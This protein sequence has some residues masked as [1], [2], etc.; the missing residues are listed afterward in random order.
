MPERI[1]PRIHQITLRPSSRDKHGVVAALGFFDGVHIGHLALFDEARK[2]AAKRGAVFAVFTFTDCGDGTYKAGAPRLTEWNERMA[3]LRE[4]GVERVYAADFASVATLTPEEFVT[5]ILRT[6]LSVE[7]A[8]CGFNFRFGHRAAADSADL[9]RLMQRAGGDC[10]ILPPLVRDD[11][12]VSS[13]AIRAFIEGGEIER[14]NALLGR[15]FTIDFPVIHGK[16]L[17]RTIGVPTINQAFP[18]GFVLPKRGVYACICEIDGQVHPAVSNVGT[19]PTVDHNA[20][21]NC[22]SHI[23]NFDGWLYGRRIRVGFLHYLREE[24]KF[25]TLDGLIQQIGQDIKDTRLLLADR[26]L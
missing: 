11:V 14:A 1:T 13:T 10:I 12:T 8:V 26:R 2:Q 25:D 5:D 4:A 17:G 9:Q 24:R 7:C 19:H 3:L 15:A 22:E 23:L 20:A 18:V 16:M 6:R 21:V